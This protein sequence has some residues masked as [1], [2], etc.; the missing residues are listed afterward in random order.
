[1]LTP[2]FNCVVKKMRIITLRRI[3][4]LNLL[5]YSK[6]RKHNIISQVNIIAFGL[7]D[8][9]LCFKLLL[10]NNVCIEHSVALLTVQLGDGH[11]GESKVLNQFQ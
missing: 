8:G 6:I 3:F 10:Q 4:R 2:Y 5:N 7:N 9:I 11:P 1:M